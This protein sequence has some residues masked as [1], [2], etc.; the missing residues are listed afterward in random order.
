M[1]E[2][3]GEGGSDDWYFWYDLRGNLS[4]KADH[5]DPAQAYYAWDYSWSS[6][7]LLTQMGPSG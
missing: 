2:D 6:R 4:R 1:T 7:D 5:T 3:D